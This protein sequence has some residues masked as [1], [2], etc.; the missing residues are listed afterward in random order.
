VNHIEELVQR[1]VSVWNETDATRRGQEV[2]ALW[3]I[4]G[5]HVMGANA[6]EGHEALEQHVVASNHR[7]VLEKNY[8]F[9]PATGIQALPGVIKF[10]WDVARRDT[11]EIVSAGIGFLIIDEDHRIS[12]DYLFAES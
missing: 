3:R 6:T 10:R 2:R 7:S 4:D 9:R 12:C 5:R 11:N 1:F 8:V